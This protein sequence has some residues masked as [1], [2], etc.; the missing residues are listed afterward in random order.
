MPAIRSQLAVSS[1]R[2]AETLGRVDLLFNDAGIVGPSAH[3]GEV[4]YELVKDI[5][6]PNLTDV[7]LCQA[8]CSWPPQETLSIYVEFTAG[9]DHS[10]LTGQ[11]ALPFVDSLRQHIRPNP[12]APSCF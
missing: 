9:L 8:A 3:T 6:D 1:A 4:F 5:L 2:V 10:R 12:G 7:S 11:G